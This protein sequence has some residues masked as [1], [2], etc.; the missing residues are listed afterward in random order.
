M[1]TVVVARINYEMA[2]CRKLMD[3]IILME[4]MDLVG[5]E[6]EA[7]AAVSRSFAASYWDHH[8][9][10]IQTARAGVRCAAPNQPKSYGHIAGVLSSC[11]D[12]CV[13]AKSCSIDE[14]CSASLEVGTTT[15]Q[16]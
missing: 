8:S 3:L 10:F 1:K 11:I 13:G 4:L 14:C 16:A 12:K 6:V 15:A 9:I 5:Q 2:R 7:L